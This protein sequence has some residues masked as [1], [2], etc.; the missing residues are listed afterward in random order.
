[1]TLKGKVA[2]VTG[3]SRG[4][5]REIVL[6]LAKEGA[7]IFF[8][9]GGRA[10]AAKETLDLVSEFGVE[11]EAMKADVSSE[12]EVQAFFKEVTNR[13]G[14]IDILVNNAGITRDN[15]LMRMK[16]D[17]WD[18]VI[19]INLKGTFLCTKA[20]ARTMMKQRAGK[21]INMTSVVGIIGNAGQANYVASKA[22][23]IGLTKT[24]ARELA[25]RGI[26]VNAVAPGFIETEMTDE[27]DENT[28]ELMLAQIPLGAYG[29]TKDIANAVKFL[30]SDESSY[31]TGQVLSID[32]GMSM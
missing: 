22:G 31:I 17:E 20:V 26:N 27:L 7:N 21:I 16:E 5:G 6:A 13:F 10:D 8:N 23:M 14:R 18:D 30:A 28:K 25:P 32:G 3:G 19:N 9:Y 1:M 15:L 12:E 11:A 4:I 24:T 2:V 29:K